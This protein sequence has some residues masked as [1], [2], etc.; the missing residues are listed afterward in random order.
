[1][2]TLARIDGEVFVPDHGFLP[3]LAGKGRYAHSQAIWD[4]LTFDKG[5]AKV[6][7]TGDI[8]RA[9]QE[10]RFSAIILPKEEFKIGTVAF[11]H[12]IEIG[13]TIFFDTSIFLPVT[14]AHK[15]VKYIFVPKN[16]GRP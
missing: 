6:L 4:V 11:N 8:Q 7:L 14:G 9:I 5:P 10:K 12:D 13:G 1:M 16:G 15:R 2:S 3:S